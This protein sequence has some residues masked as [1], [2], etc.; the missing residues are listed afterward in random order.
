MFFLVYFLICDEL[1]LGCCYD[2]IIVGCC[3]LECVVG[4]MGLSNFDCLVS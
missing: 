2:S 3:Y 1:C 4:C